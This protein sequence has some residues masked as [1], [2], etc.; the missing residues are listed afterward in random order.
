ME[1]EN[2]ANRNVSFVECK[3]GSAS[4]PG[5]A[6]GFSIDYGDWYCNSSSCREVPALKPHTMLIC[7]SAGKPIP[8]KAE[9]L[10]IRVGEREDGFM[11]IGPPFIFIRTGKQMTFDFG[12][13]LNQ[14]FCV[15]CAIP[16]SEPSNTHTVPCKLEPWVFGFF[17]VSTAKI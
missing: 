17:L 5:P 6:S 8:M 9:D 2:S 1:L 13:V 11:F 14:D 16:H 12:A 10:L 7:C 4:H 15:I 3:M